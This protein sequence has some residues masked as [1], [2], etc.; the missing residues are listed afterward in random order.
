MGPMALLAAVPLFVLVVYFGKYISLGSI[1]TAGSF[2][3]LLILFNYNINTVLLIYYHRLSH[4]SQAQRNIIRLIRGEEKPW[5]RKQ[6]GRDRFENHG[7]AK[8]SLIPSVRADSEGFTN[9][10]ALPTLINIP[11]TSFL[12]WPFLKDGK[13]SPF[14]FWV[15][16]PD[17]LP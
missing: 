12:F 6:A 17:L 7:D 3:I 14:S 9:F 1:I 15:G 16:Y 4:Y 8:G 13:P 11:N 2:P 10:I 5:T